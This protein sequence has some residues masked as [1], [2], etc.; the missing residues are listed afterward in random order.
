M[1]VFN[2]FELRSWDRDLFLG[3]FAN[4]Q[5]AEAA[6]SMILAKRPVMQIDDFTIEQAVIGELLPFAFEED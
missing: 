5:D 1:D 3:S 4:N 2:L 6:I